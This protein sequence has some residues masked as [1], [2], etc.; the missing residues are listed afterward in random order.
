MSHCTA[1]VN[2]AHFLNRLLQDDNI[3]DEQHNSLFD[4][5]SVCCPCYVEAVQTF[6]FLFYER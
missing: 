4:I 6:E 2:P 5:D 1:W 3:T